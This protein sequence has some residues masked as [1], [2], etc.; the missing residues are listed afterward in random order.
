[1]SISI[2]TPF[3]PYAVNVY[4]KHSEDRIPDGHRMVVVMFKGKDGKASGKPSLVVAI[5][6][7][8]A[9][10]PMP[11][12]R[13]AAFMLAHTFKAT[14]N[15]MVGATVRHQINAGVQTGD[16]FIDPDSLEADTVLAYFF[17]DKQS[18]GRITSD[19]IEGWFNSVIA[20][21]LATLVKTKVPTISEAALQ[22]ATLSYRKLVCQLAAQSIS[23]SLSKVTEARAAVE[24]AP[25]SN[26]RAILLRKLDTHAE[27]LREDSGV[28]ISI[29]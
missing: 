5:P 10:V 23:L 7:N 14:Q 29:A 2:L 27:K 26:M 16:V 4:D 18:T 25:E 13:H 22:K 21:P 28:E 3:T 20:P 15:E 9:S 17:N 19:Q 6:D 12:D 8:V 11:E 1:M 24:L